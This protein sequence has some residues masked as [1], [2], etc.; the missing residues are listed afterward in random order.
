MDPRTCKSTKELMQ[1]RKLTMEKINN[2]QREVD[3]IIEDTD[4]TVENKTLLISKLI[5]TSQ[6]EFVDENL[7]KI[8]KNKFL[9]L[10]TALCPK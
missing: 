4:I 2:R 9:P 7:A 8:F 3:L 10:S 5:T 6:K 1:F